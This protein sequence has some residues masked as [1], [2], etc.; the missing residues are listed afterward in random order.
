[1]ARPHPTQ[2]YSVGWGLRFQNE[3]SL[4]LAVSRYKDCERAVGV[5]GGDARARL[6]DIYLHRCT[7]DYHQNNPNHNSPYFDDNR[8]TDYHVTGAEYDFSRVFCGLYCDC[9]RYHDDFAA[10]NHRGQNDKLPSLHYAYSLA[11]KFN[12]YVPD[13]NQI[14]IPS[15][16]PAQPYYNN[17][18]YH[19]LHNSDNFRRP[20]HNYQY[21][22]Y[23]HFR[24]RIHFYT[25]V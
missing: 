18:S 5:G 23:H 3:G 13:S 9:E 10:Y 6:Y 17:K 2:A 12:L 14:H 8:E 25:A 11:S 4:H 20:I 24:I 15:I 21:S 22:S 1:M 19:T 7:V 16:N